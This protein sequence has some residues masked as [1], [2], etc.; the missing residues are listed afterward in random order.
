MGPIEF[1]LDVTDD[2][3]II[4]PGTVF[5]PTVETVYAVYPFSGMSKGLKFAVVWYYQGV[6]L[7]REEIEWPFGDRASSYSFI[8]PRGPGLYKLELYVNDTVVATKLFEVR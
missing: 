4:N 5:S 6:E 1:G 8:H 2:L 3:K 7:A